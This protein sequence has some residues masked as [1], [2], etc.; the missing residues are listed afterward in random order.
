MTE[1]YIGL[2][3]GTSV[4]GIDAVVAEFGETSLD[5]IAARSHPYPPRLQADLHRAISNP[6]SLGTDEF[7]DLH[8]RVGEA[9]RDAANVLLA[10]AAMVPADI[11]AIGS[12]GQTLRHRPDA[13]HRFTLQIGDAAT[14]ASGTGIDTV[15]DFR[16]IDMALGGQ[17][18][19]LVP[20]FHAWLMRSTTEDRVVLNI[21]GIANIT[22][23]PATGDITGFDTGPGNTLLDAWARTS[24]GVP[25]DE[26]GAWAAGGT[27]HS[28][29]VDNALADPWFHRP[30]PKSTG[31]EYFNLEWLE[32]KRPAGLAGADVQASLAEV[33][34]RSIAAAIQRWAPATS[35]VF[36]CGG[37]VRNIDLMRRLAAM[38][39]D[40]QVGTTSDAGLDPAW[41]EATA[42]AWLARQCVRGMPG[43]LPSVTGARRH[44]ILGAVYRA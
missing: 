38:L 7:G 39:P 10:A 12:H 20:P 19:P 11:R 22:I 27:M 29:F 42:F 6:G 8:I 3:S 31:F 2:M 37:G 9:F 21:G 43:N 32:K 30:P 40:V 18:A 36:A 35:R 23:L 25:F 15:A 13:A 26:R 28:A 33:S 4:D 14:I 24:L 41:V 17:G 16:S 44:A 5:L 34:A 1:R